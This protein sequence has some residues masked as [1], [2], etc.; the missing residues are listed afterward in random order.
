MHWKARS[1][2]ACRIS[3]IS[4]P[5]ECGGFAL[6][7]RDVAE[8]VTAVARGDGGTAWIT[9]IASGFARVVMTFPSQTV[10]E[11]YQR[12]A[13]WPGPIVAGASLFSEKVQ[14]G[15]K[16][17]GGYI[18]NA[19]GKWGFGSGCKHAA[20]VCVGIEY[21]DAERQKRRGMALLEKGQYHI[22][23]DWHVMG[24][25][26]SSSNSVATNQDI[27]VAEQRLVELAQFP[28]RLDAIRGNYTGAGYR[29]N[30]LGLMLYVAL[31]TMAIVLGMAWGTFECFVEQAKARKPFN[32]P[33]K[34]L[35]EMPSMHVTAGKARAMINSAQAVLYSRAD[36][37]DAMARQDLTV[38]P[39]QEGEFMM[40]FAHAGSICGQAVDMLQLA[41]GSSTISENNPIQRFARDARVALTHGSTRLDPL[42]EITGRQILG[43]PPFAGFS[44][45]IPG[46]PDA[47]GKS[48]AALR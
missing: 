26:A 1:K 22:V 39:T 17:D 29:L 3:R 6:G 25:S 35:S 40:D 37:L 46:V 31:E 38:S 44:G 13:D 43:Q 9:M 11:I 12:S 45:A 5:V 10:H 7:A 47:A 32:L 21:E 36:Q 2:V 28:Q 14:H 4:I 34:T 33:Y 42:A 15:R 41:I 23:D 30:G 27:F 24:L 19:G 18:V 20:Y 8:I 16:V 48:A